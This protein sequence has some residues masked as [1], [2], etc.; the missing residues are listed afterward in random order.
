M[1]LDDRLPLSLGHFFGKETNLHS[2]WDTA[3]IE[4]RISGDFHSQP[5]LYLD[6][7]LDQ[8]RT[9]YAQNISDWIACPSSDESRFLACATKWISEDAQLN[10]AIVYR[11][12]NNEP[13]ST[14]KEF[15]LGQTYYNTRTV[16]VEQRLIQGGVRL[17][18]VINKIVQ[19]AEERD[20]S[21]ETQYEIGMI[22]YLLIGQS[23]I[24]IAFVTFR[25][26]RR[27]SMARWQT[28][29]F[30]QRKEYLIIG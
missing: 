24:I 15:T 2:V 14:S 5:L 25:L 4:R 23:L 12:E 3:M 9:V 16:I 6:Y 10:C 26:L 19:L 11:D 8:M 17:A 7:L 28:M 21:T 29:A 22:G 30:E 1:T 27:Q 20:P 18:A 13:M